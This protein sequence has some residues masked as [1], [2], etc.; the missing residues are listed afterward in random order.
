MALFLV[1]PV[2]LLIHVS[3]Y[4]IPLHHFS[5]CAFVGCT[6]VSLGVFP[7]N[8]VL[9]VVNKGYVF[10]VVCGLQQVADMCAEL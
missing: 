2:K 5:S 8:A 7:P 3:A 4:K 9:T 6:G 1:C 10:A